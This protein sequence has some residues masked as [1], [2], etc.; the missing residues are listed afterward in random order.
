[1]STAVEQLPLA[2]GR[3]ARGA[4]LTAWGTCGICS[5]AVEDTGY[6]VS[7]RMHHTA[8]LF[9]M[10]T[11]P[12]CGHRQLGRRLSRDQLRRAYP[13]HYLVRGLDPDTSSWR[14]RFMRARIGEME[15]ARVE[16]ARRYVRLGPDTR[17]LDVGCGNGTFVRKLES[18]TGCVCVGIEPDRASVERGRADGLDMRCGTLDDVDVGGQPFDL[19]TMWHCLE[20]VHDPLPQLAR[21]A[22]LLRSGGRMI[23]AV[24]DAGGLTARLF[25]GSWF[26]LDAPRHVHQFTPAELTLLCERAGLNVTSV[27][28]VTELSTF[29]GSVHNALGLRWCDDV[30]A[31][32]VKW[33]ALQALCMPADILLRLLGRGDWMVLAAERPA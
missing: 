22:G 18:A 9:R 3:A 17:A 10:V 7:D 15:S 26:G 1:M 33:V 2:P 19:V 8:G 30:Q 12:A 21:A 25:G 29:A 11:C 4:P 28:H 16:L 20:H 24:P 32:L 6:L 5:A 13:S 31:N 27:E 23:I 14:G